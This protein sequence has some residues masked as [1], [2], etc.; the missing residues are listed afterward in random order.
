MVT[1]PLS[2]AYFWTP[3][4]SASASPAFTSSLPKIFGAMELTTRRK[5]SGRFE[6]SS[7]TRLSFTPIGREL[8]SLLCRTIEFV[9]RYRLYIDV[10]AVRTLEVAMLLITPQTV[11]T[12]PGM[13]LSMRSSVTSHSSIFGTLPESEVSIRFSCSCNLMHCQSTV[14]ARE[15]TASRVRLLQPW[16]EHF[17]GA[18]YSPWSKYITVSCWHLVQRKGIETTSCCTCPTLI[19]VPRTCEKQP[20]LSAPMF[21]SGSIVVYSVTRKCTLPRTGLISDSAVKVARPRQQ[22]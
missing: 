12:S 17:G 19:T 16:A 3:P 21:C 4:K 20:I 11:K 15:G 10:V 22:R 8:S 18:A 5:T 6:I 9:S 2:S 1:F 7:T 13:H 14:V